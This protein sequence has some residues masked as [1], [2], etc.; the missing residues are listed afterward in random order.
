MDGSGT[1]QLGCSAGTSSRCRCLPALQ[2]RCDWT[3]GI[4]AEC[5]HVGDGRTDGLTVGSLTWTW[6]WAGW[7]GGCWWPA[8]KPPAEWPPASYCNRPCRA[9][10]HSE[11]LSRFLCTPCPTP[12]PLGHKDVIKMRLGQAVLQFDEHTIHLLHRNL[13]KD[14]QV[15]P[16]ENPPEDAIEARV[17]GIKQSLV[18]YAIRHE[19]H[20]KEEEEEEDILHLDSQK[21]LSGVKIQRGL[22]TWRCLPVPSWFSPF[23]QQWWF[24]A[25]V[26]C[27]WQRCG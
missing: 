1:E 12:S 9:Q 18:G 11:S 27:E 22:K 19:P 10:H 24:L 2:W 23:S 3:D 8:D 6:Q 16:V 4:R 25:P 20:P 21:E 5:P 26:V 15:R 17:V 14:V 7:W 13:S